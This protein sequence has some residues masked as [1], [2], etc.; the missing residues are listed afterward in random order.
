[1]KQILVIIIVQGR[2]IFILYSTLFL[3]FLTYPDDITIYVLT[4]I[5]HIKYEYKR[6]NTGT[7]PPN[8]DTSIKHTSEWMVKQWMAY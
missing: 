7:T 5:K 8:T 6:E 2:G 4:G 3:F 1:M